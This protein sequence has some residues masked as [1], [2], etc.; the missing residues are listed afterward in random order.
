MTLCWYWR[1]R[2]GL[3]LQS[4]PA[5]FASERHFLVDFA[6][7]HWCSRALPAAKFFNRAD[8]PVGR[9]QWLVDESGGANSRNSRRLGMQAQTAGGTAVSGLEIEADTVMSLITR[10]Q[11]AA[12]SQQMRMMGMNL[13]MPGDGGGDSD[14][15]TNG[16]G[17][18][19]LNFRPDYGTNLWLAISSVS[20]G[21]VSLCLSNTVYTQTGEVYEVMSKTNL[22]DAAWNIETEVWAV[23]NQNWV[24]F[25]I[26]VLDRTNALF[27]WAKDWTGVTSGGNQ[28]P[29]WW[30]W[31]Y[32]GRVDLSDSGMDADGVNTLLCDY[33]NSMDPNHIRFALQFTNHD[34]NTSTVSGTISVLGGVPF[35]M[36]VLLNDTNLADAVWLPYNPHPAIQA[37]DGYY[38]VWVGLRGLP[39]D[40]TQTWAWADFTVDTVPPVLV[41]TSPGKR[42][43]FPAHDST[44]RLC[45]R[46]VEWF[47]F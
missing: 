17:F 5:E 39:S 7:R 31:Y 1:R 41:I 8:F 16:V 10:V 27:V 45:Q 21:V 6:K 20:N 23:S 11:M 22:S 40:A 28:T 2:G 18:Y 46:A 34:Y 25:T 33:T 36:A 26:P 13:P 47:D 43:C 37:A 42:H 4:D 14:G 30:F 3:S 9:N 15:N 29:D 19:G 32:Y 24:A 35:Y 38:S 12:A 44:A